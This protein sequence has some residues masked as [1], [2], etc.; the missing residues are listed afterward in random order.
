V[1]RAL[2]FRKFVGHQPNVISLTKLNA[3][4][5]D[6]ISPGIFLFLRFEGVGKRVLF[7]EGF[8][9]V[10]DFNLAVYLICENVGDCALRVFFEGVQ[11]ER[12]RAFLFEGKPVRRRGELW[13]TA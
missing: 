13:G 6:V 11:D 5:L 2:D 8:L 7:L 1:T 10:K 12:K 3:A 9:L 4:P